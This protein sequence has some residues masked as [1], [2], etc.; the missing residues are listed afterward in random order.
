MVNAT[1]SAGVNVSATMREI[2]IEQAIVSA[3]CLYNSPVVSREEADRN[4]DG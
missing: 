3:N 1:A 2:E 4:K